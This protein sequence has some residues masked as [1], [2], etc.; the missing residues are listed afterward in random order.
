MTTTSESVQEAFG[1]LFVAEVAELKRLARMLPQNPIV[2]NIGA[3]AGTSGLAFLESRPDLTLYTIDIQN[4]SS[5]YGCLEGERVVVEGAGLGDQWEVRWFQIHGDSSSIGEDW[6]SRPVDM[7]FIDGDH[8]YEGC[9]RDIEAWL[10]KI[11]PGGIISVH[12]YLKAD[13]FA[14]PDDGSKKPHPM[15]WEG[16]DSSVRVNLISRGL[17]VISHVDSLISFWV[18]GDRD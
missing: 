10:P 3:G 5:P 17:D 11:K 9:T 1:Y 12:D 13:V 2:I 15:A 16:V 6:I 7:V 8:S 14:R 4:E 18:E